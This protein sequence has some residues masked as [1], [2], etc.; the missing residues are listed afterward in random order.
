MATCANC[1]QAILFGGVKHGTLR[2]CNQRCYNAA[3]QHL[4]LEVDVPE[5]EVDEAVTA[6]HQSDCP[7]C[8]GPGPIDFHYSYRVMSF[9][10]LTQFRTIPKISCRA[11]ARNAKLG[12]FFATL[13]LGWWGFPFGLIFTP[14]YLGR[15]LYSLCFPVPEDTPSDQLR[16]FVRL[17]IAQQN[18]IQAAVEKSQNSDMPFSDAE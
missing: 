10:V 13:L 17:N 14:I 8:G 6:F 18:V 12:N 7:C 11:C 2:F 1:G 9:V 15:N 16:E 5:N 3:K 4:H